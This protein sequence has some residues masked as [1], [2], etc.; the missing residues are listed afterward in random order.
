MLRHVLAGLD[1]ASF[2]GLGTRLDWTSQQELHDRVQAHGSCYVCTA[3][4]PE[5]YE[6]ETADHHKCS[7]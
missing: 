4:R 1:L 7:T 2:P 5:L 3:Y 6:L